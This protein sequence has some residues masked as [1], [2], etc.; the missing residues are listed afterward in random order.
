MSNGCESWQICNRQMVS[1]S[2]RYGRNNE[3]CILRV[4]AVTRRSVSVLI[5]EYSFKD[6]AH[7]LVTK[8]PAIVDRM[9]A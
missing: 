1:V 8:P 5:Y 4:G 2:H 7:R 9:L 3:F 6:D